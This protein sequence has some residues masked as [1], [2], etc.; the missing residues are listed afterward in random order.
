MFRFGVSSEQTCAPI[1]WWKAE[2]VF[3]YLYKYKL[4]VHPAYAMTQG[5]QWDRKRI[6]VASLGGR[7]GRGMGRAQWERA[8]YR[9]VLSKLR[10]AKEV[11]L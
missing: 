7:R 9:D 10:G 5:G 2:D 6:R 1:G 4:P 8:Y 3:A 11:E